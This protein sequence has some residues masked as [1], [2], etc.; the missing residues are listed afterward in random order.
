MCI[1]LSKIAF[2]R[3]KAQSK[4]MLFL[5]K[6]LMFLVICLICFEY[7]VALE[8]KRQ[9]QYNK[10]QNDE[11]MLND[12]HTTED[13]IDCALKVF[14]TTLNEFKNREQYI[15]A[16]PR[17]SSRLSRSN[18]RKLISVKT[19][20]S[21]SFSFSIRLFFLIFFLFTYLFIYLIDCLLAFSYYF[22][23]VTF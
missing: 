20:F 9:A 2:R 3:R 1:S 12:L 15:R 7:S 10:R 16:D 22:L 17:F 5:Y 6:I 8:R 4:A 23:T 18:P 11:E 14:K 13:D 21:V 19:F